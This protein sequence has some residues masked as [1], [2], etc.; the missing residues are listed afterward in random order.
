MGS[1]RSVAGACLRCGFS[2]QWS[3][4]FARAWNRD[5]LRARFVSCACCSASCSC[6]LA[7]AVACLFPCLSALRLACSL[8]FCAVCCRAARLSC[9]CLLARAISSGLFACIASRSLA[10]SL[11]RSLRASRVVRRSLQLRA[12]VVRSPLCALR[13]HCCLPVSVMPLTFQ[14]ALL[15]SLALSAL[16][17][18]APPRFDEQSAVLARGSEKASAVAAD[19]EEC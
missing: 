8:R 13:W 1:F 10:R 7:R 19:A 15:C 17:A 18:S 11:S 14:S 2:R 4:S 12:F 3:T 6:P 16:A 5:V 9:S